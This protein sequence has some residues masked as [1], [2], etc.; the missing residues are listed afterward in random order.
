MSLWCLPRPRPAVTSGV[1][2]LLHGL[3]DARIL[4]LKAAV[5]GDVL[6]WVLSKEDQGLADGIDLL[7]R[8]G[9]LL[10]HPLLGVCP[11]AWR[12]LY[13]DNGHGEISSQN[14]WLSR[15]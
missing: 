9:D 12:G 10:H 11:D 3:Q 7:D 1:L 14:S 8:G 2:R 4:G 15:I 6:K 13:E 5:Q